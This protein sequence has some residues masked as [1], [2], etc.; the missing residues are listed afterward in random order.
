MSGLESF[1]EGLDQI[2][3][4]L[5]GLLGARFSICREVA[6]YKRV[7]GVAMMQPDRVA[8]VRARYLSHGEQADLPPQFTE[9]L[10]ELLIAATCEMEDELIAGGSSAKERALR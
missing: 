1:R 10:F 2:D 4:Q 3:Q 6:D 8:Q 7:H 5:I 9:S